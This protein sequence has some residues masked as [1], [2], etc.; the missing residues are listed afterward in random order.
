MVKQRVKGALSALNGPNTYGNS[1]AFWVAFA[2][3][4]LGVFA[5]PTTM[6][7]YGAGEASLYLLYAFLA[8][9]LCF[10]WGYCGVLSFGQVAFFGIAGYTF[11]IVTLNTSAA[12][13]LPA[14]LAAVAVAT[15]ASLLVG[16]F[17]FYGGVRDVYVAIV[18]LV[19][20]LVLHTFMAQT[21]GSEWKVGSARLGGFNGMPGIPNIT[22]GGFGL[23][24]YSMYYTVA[25]LLVLTYLGLRVLINSRYGRVMVAVREDESRAQMLGYNTKLVKLAVFTFGGLLAGF[26]GVLFASWGNYVDPSVFS[27][28]FAAVPI[29]W[30]SVG[31]RDSL[32]GAIL[33][34]YAVESF[35]QS[36]AATGSQWALVI[37]GGLLLLVI[38]YMPQ[39]A[40]PQLDRYVKVGMRRLKRRRATGEEDKEVT[41]VD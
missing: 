5:Y 17:M 12:M 24:G 13:S 1:R 41:S 37:I 20:T 34:T 18:T 2:V 29:V 36:L 8:L 40:V 15:L 3:G 30:V 35:S 27:L 4:V 10:M 28:S 33:A 19:M 25:V 22:V 26:G 9:S 11:G 16:Y 39:G 7:A 32:I 6:G 38:M 21:A 31:G 14:L 23:S